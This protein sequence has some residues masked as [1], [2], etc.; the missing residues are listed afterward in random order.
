MEKQVRFIFT[1]LSQCFYCVCVCVCVF[2][3]VLRNKL[4][5]LTRVFKHAKK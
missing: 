1:N 5:I 3:Y 2:Q 4:H